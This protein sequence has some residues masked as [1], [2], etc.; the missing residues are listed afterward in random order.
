MTGAHKWGRPCRR[1]VLWLALLIAAA[2]LIV[3]SFS[4][5]Q[6]VGGA[7]ATP[8]EVQIKLERFG[9]GNI[10]RPGDWCGIR[11]AI[12]DTSAKQRELIVR[13]DGL[14]ADGDTPEYTREI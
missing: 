12:M 5:A 6:G 10:A 4:L 11:V 2:V 7:G 8:G 1:P 3:P 9:V 14:D 13:L